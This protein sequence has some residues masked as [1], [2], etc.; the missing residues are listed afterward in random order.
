MPCLMWLPYLVLKGTSDINTDGDYQNDFR[1]YPG[2]QNKECLFLNGDVTKNIISSVSF[3]SVC[4][5]VVFY[6]LFF[7]CLRHNADCFY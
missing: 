2:D 4:S 3:R 6:K 7:I 1:Y 5:S